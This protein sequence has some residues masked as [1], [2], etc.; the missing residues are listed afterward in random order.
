MRETYKEGLRLL[1]LAAGCVLLVACANV[2]NLLLLSRLKYRSQTALQAAL[3]A[4]RVRLVCKGLGASLTLALLGGVAGI[5]LAYA[6][7]SAILSFAFSGSDQWAPIDP[8]PSF[9]VLLFA[10]GITL[11]TG[12][13]CG[14][15]PA[16]IILRID[17]IQALRGCRSRGGNHSWAQKT[18][19]SIQATISI[20]L[21]S[22]ATMLGQSLHNLEYQNFGLI[23]GAAI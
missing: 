16:W 9:T 3:G 22:A 14:I 6:G 17:L 15:A 12:V 13:A 19:V 2:A 20:V 11:V 4:P 5:A 8:T 18:L 7:A 1:L 23:Q 21:V 10:L